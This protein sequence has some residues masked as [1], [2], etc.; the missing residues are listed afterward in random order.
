[1]RNTYQDYSDFK[2]F[3]QD[4]LFH[5]FSA[6]ANNSILNCPLKFSFSSRS[7]NFS[8]YSI[9]VGSISKSV[10]WL[11]TQKYKRTMSALFINLVAFY[12]VY[13][14]ISFTIDQ[15]TQ[16][17]STRVTLSMLLFCS[18]KSR[19]CCMTFVEQM[20]VL[21]V[22]RKSSTYDG[23]FM[24]LGL[25]IANCATDEVSSVNCSTSLYSEPRII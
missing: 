17:N 3:F 14:E 18:I 24:T 4:L 5:T 10:K 13:K 21:C 6:H 8:R 25:C 7:S 22:S 19:R 20:N 15:P 9:I 1:M 2:T 23:S 16:S 12:Q 11:C